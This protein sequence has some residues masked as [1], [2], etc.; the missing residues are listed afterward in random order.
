VLLGPIE[1]S[2]TNEDRDSMPL[3]SALVRGMVTTAGFTVK[4]RLKGFVA[5]CQLGEDVRSI[6]TDAALRQSVKEDLRAL[7]A[8]AN[9]IRS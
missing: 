5:S 1:I 4:R 9:G 6:G 3:T 7:N 2:I 8:A